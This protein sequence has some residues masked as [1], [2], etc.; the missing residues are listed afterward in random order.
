MKR[1]R[2]VFLAVCVLA[3]TMASMLPAEASASK[4]GYGGYQYGEYKWITC[5]TVYGVHRVVNEFDVS[6]TNN[7]AYKVIGHHQIW[8]CYSTGSPCTTIF[9]TS[10]RTFNPNDGITSN[11]PWPSTGQYCE[12]YPGWNYTFPE[13]AKLYDTLW[14]YIGGTYRKDAQ[15][16]AIIIKY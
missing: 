8:W 1:Y 9:N 14:E 16:P 15:T 4:C 7:S 13:G 6:F 11:C 12:E 5:L 10:Q 2:I 3:F